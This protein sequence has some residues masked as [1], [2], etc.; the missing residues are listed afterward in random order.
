MENY[1]QNLA[2]IAILYLIYRFL[3]FYAMGNWSESLMCR[4]EKIISRT[5]GDP[6]KQRGSVESV[7]FKTGIKPTTIQSSD[8]GLS[9][10]LEGYH[11][12]YNQPNLLF[13]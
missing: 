13:S 1:G 9:L 2:V 4:L 6:L 8:Q 11:G 12:D 5:I 10:L 3:N 7:G